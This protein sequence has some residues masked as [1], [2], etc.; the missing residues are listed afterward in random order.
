MFDVS[1]MNSNTTVQD[2]SPRTFPAVSQNSKQ[3][4]L[5]GPVS[6][7]FLIGESLGRGGFGEVFTAWDK[8]SGSLTCVRVVKPSRCTSRRE[9][10][11]QIDN[12]LEEIHKYLKLRHENLI[13]YK[14]LIL[15]G[16][17]DIRGLS[18]VTT[19]GLASVKCLLPLSRSE[20]TFVIRGLASGLAF[21]HARGLVHGHV[22]P[23][24]VFLDDCGV[25]KISDYGLFLLMPESCQIR[26]WSPPEIKT[27]PQPSD[28][29]I[30]PSS[31]DVWSLGIAACHF[32]L[33][34]LPFK[35][36]KLSSPMTKLPLEIQN[37]KLGRVVALCLNLDPV[38]RVTA[39]LLLEEVEVS[40]AEVGL[41]MLSRVL[42]GPELRA[43]D[44]SQARDRL[45]CDLCGEDT[46]YS[47]VMTNETGSEFL[48]D[49]CLEEASGH[50]KCQRRVS[51]CSEC[52]ELQKTLCQRWRR[53]RS[54]DTFFQRPK[55]SGTSVPSNDLGQDAKQTSNSTLKQMEENATDNHNSNQKLG[56][57]SSEMKDGMH[58][59]QEDVSNCPEL[60]NNI[61]EELNNNKCETQCE[62]R[63]KK[64][65]DC[66]VCLK[67][68]STVSGL[69][70]IDS[71]SFICEKCI[72]EAN[73][74]Y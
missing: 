49:N 65:L 70:L 5:S 51:D 53:Q 66:G 37:S 71:E 40:G 57:D 44:K 50:Q 10:I 6:K 59:S 64:A 74:V 38:S 3:S 67:K 63:N 39:D 62:F 47:L 72:A 46:G 61:V 4:S 16:S 25:V 45:G 9:F 27:I 52:S 31:A 34:T 17:L 36:H 11:K 14:S 41:E 68:G 24:S 48:C 43:P 60:E 42:I 69:Y 55:A 1:R 30:Q 15:T 23:E 29:R 73:S 26:P 13:R 32:I 12:N 20:C 2:S 58:N 35:N 22:C 19:L 7:H 56:P 18:L 21:L 28:N 33:G 8:K 54:L